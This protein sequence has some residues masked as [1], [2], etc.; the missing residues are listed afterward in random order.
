MKSKKTNKKN[1]Y[2]IVFKKQLRKTE[3]SMNSQKRQM[4]NTSRQKS[5]QKHKENQKKATKNN[6]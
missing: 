2:I 5:K 4:K 1:S 6:K 3:K